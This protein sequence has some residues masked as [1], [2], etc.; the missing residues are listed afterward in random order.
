LNLKTRQAE[1]YATE[2]AAKIK[3]DVLAKEQK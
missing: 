3:K 1:E 2:I